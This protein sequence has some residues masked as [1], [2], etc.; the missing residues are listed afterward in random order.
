MNNPYK[1]W[2]VRKLREQR[3]VFMVK[4][5][6]HYAEANGLGTHLK[7][8]NEALAE[9]GVIVPKKERGSDDSKSRHKT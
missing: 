6:I 8:M 4:I 7:L 1:D 3:S 9:K 5:G 2:S